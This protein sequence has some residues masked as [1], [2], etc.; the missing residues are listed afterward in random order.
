M[1]ST[2]SE[3]LFDGARFLRAYKD[4]R[5]ER[6]VGTQIVSPGLDPKTNIESKDVLYSQETGESVRLYV[7]KNVSSTQKLPL[8]VY[9]H[10]GGFCIETAFSPT[11]HNY[12]NS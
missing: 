8:L 6:L 1:E 12:L 2:T 4:G 11:Y 7:P 5:V 10:G 9:F 3:I